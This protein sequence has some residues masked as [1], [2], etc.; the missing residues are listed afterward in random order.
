MPYKHATASE[1]CS[2]PAANWDIFLAA[3]ECY[4]TSI[5]LFK[6]FIVKKRTNGKKNNKKRSA[7]FSTYSLLIL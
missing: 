5:F 2:M 3:E 7:T 1:T 4:N 6:S